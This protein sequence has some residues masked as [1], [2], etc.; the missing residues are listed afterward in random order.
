MIRAKPVDKKTIKKI[1]EK[2]CMSVIPEVCEDGSNEK[3]E[4]YN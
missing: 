1:A 2:A 3:P 4:L